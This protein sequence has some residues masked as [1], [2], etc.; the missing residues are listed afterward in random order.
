MSYGQKGGCYGLQS[1]LLNDPQQSKN[2]AV[3]TVSEHHLAQL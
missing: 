3:T 2:I 1:R